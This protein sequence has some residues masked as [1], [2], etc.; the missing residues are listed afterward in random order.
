MRARGI[1]LKTFFD[2]IKPLLF[3][4][5]GLFLTVMMYLSF[6]PSLADNPELLQSLN[7]M[8]DA[9]KELVGSFS[10]FGTPEG[11][12]QAEFFSITLP[13]L[14]SIVAISL[15]SGLINKEEASGTIELLLARPV[16]RG[17]IVTEKA[18]VM[19]VIL[20]KMVAVL[21][22]SFAVGM[23]LIDF[24]LHFGYLLAALLAVYLVAAVFGMLALAMTTIWA[25]R[26][27]AIAVASLLYFGSYVVSSFAGSIDIFEKIQN[28]SVFRYYQT[29]DMLKHGPVWSDFVVLAVIVA[30]LL[31]VAWFAFRKRDLNV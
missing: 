30:V 28:V 12:A 22:I 9:F 26:G 23:A 25:S 13:L 19:L 8:P 17:R 14:L 5:I 27:L 24:P 18:L 31:G 21:A 3:W 29:A 20:L 10:E 4:G 2:Y 7:A 1:F 6:Y 15:G 16:S 11:Y